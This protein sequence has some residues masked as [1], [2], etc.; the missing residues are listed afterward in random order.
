MGNSKILINIFN[1]E[2]SIN[3]F[4]SAKSA[5]IKTFFQRR[6]FPLSNFVK[7]PL[8]IILCFKNFLI[9]V[10][11]RFNM[12]EFE[13]NS[14]SASFTAKF[15]APVLVLKSSSYEMSR[16]YRNSVERLNDFR[17]IDW[18]FF[19]GYNVDFF[20][21][22]SLDWLIDRSCDWFD[23]RLVVWLIDCSIDWL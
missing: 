3:I 16:K 12:T 8:K 1:S 19:I 9:K 2:I 7:W 10:D 14:I 17:G 6:F 22:W 18:L 21:C 4:T 20:I 13:K 11:R 5:D 15:R 23:P